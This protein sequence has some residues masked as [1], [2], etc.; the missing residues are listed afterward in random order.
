MPLVLRSM[1]ATLSPYS[2]PRLKKKEICRKL[3]CRLLGASDAI[4]ISHA[5][6]TDDQ[7]LASVGEHV[8]DFILVLIVAMLMRWKK[9]HRIKKE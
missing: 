9:K 1:N 5:I 8:A 3:L 2:A 7:T 4:I 6:K